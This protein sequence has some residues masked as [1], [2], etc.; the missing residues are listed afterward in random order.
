MGVTDERPLRV[1]G[2]RRTRDGVFYLGRCP[3]GCPAADM[4]QSP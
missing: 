2:S 1:A 3:G 4:R